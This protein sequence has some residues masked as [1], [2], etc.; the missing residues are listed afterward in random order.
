[1]GGAESYY[2]AW[3]AETA[4]G[5]RCS[6]LARRALDGAIVFDRQAGELCL[7]VAASATCRELLAER[8]LPGWRVNWGETRGY[9]RDHACE[10]AFGGT[11][12]QAEACSTSG[13]C[14]EGLLCDND[15]ALKGSCSHTCVQRFVVEIDEPCDGLRYACPDGYFC[16]SRPGEQWS[17]CRPIAEAGETCDWL[18][19]ANCRSGTYCDEGL[20]APSAMVGDGCDYP[21]LGVD[22][23]LDSGLVCA[24]DGAGQLACASW[25][26]FGEPCAPVGRS[27]LAGYCD[28]Q[29]G[30]VCRPWSLLGQPCPPE[31]RSSCLTGRCVLRGEEGRCEPGGEAGEDCQDYLDCGRGTHCDD[32]TCREN[33]PPC[34]R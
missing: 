3:D 10:R 13:D 8:L 21:A 1:M 4:N 26:R 31:V 30:G 25:A 16:L 22:S 18:T 29:A 24:G 14:L 20:C 23:C 17:D 12:G 11:A 19:P 27:C 15:P 32:G 34:S 7:A 2:A 5:E 33:S 28:H 9:Q 6:E